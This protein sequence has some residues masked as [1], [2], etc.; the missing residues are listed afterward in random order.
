M[1]QVHPVWP[2]VQGRFMLLV[3]GMPL[4]HCEAVVHPCP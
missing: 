1:M 3:Q 4:Q 2:E